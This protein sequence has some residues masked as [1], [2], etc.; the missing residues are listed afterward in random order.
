MVTMIL[1]IIAVS[2]D[3]MSFGFS[4]GINNQRLNFFT[5]LIM[6]SLSTVLFT[7]PLL[8]SSL[9]FKYFDK[10][11]LNII[12]GIILIILSIIYFFIFIKNKRK[13][14]NNKKNTTENRSSKN[15]TLKIAILATFPISV[16]AMFTALLNGYSFINYIIAIC[17]YFFITFISLLLTNLVGLK[18]QSKSN[19]DL[20]WT[21][22]FVFLIIGLLKLFGI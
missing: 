2:F 18:I 10:T 22:S 5:M 15:T 6:T 1:L 8:L 19:I 11:I 21:S 12:K 20:G 14:T 17:L 3:A 13:H 16:D 7:I 9:I 4:Q